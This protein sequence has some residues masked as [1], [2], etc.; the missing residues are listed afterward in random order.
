M[1]IRERILETSAG[2]W[3]HKRFFSADSANSIIVKDYLRPESGEKVLDV[4]CGV[5][6][7]VNHVGDAT[8]VGVDQNPDYI[9]RAQRMSEGRG[10]F[11]NASVQE[12]P[13]LGLGDFDSPTR[14]RTSC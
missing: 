1:N 2:Y 5:G 10:T 3:S 14:P 11:I 9:A 6:D 8:Y 4:G 7:V 13:S 12:L